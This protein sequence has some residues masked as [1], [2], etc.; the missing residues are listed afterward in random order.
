VHGYLYG[1]HFNCD[2]CAENERREIQSQMEELK[3]EKE[4]LMVK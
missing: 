1:E 2:L 3:K 4:S